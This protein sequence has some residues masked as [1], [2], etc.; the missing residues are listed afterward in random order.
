MIAR[1]HDISRHNGGTPAYGFLKAAFLCCLLMLLSSSCTRN[2]GDIGKWFGK[3][4]IME[5]RVD[6]Q[7]EEDYEPRFFMEFQNDII[8]LVWVGPTGYD[9]E[10]YYCYGTWQ[11][12]SDNAMILDFTHSDDSGRLFYVPFGALHFPGDKP[13]TL[14]LSDDSGKNCTMKYVDETTSTEYTYLLRKR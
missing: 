8:R 5:I 6:G 9:R 4:Q 11:Q 14:T 13:F 2:N 7:P 1:I 10:T 3:W 12:S